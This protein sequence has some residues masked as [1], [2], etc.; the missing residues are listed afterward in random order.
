[1]I[2]NFGLIDL[3]YQGDPFTWSNRQVGENFI[4]ERLDR[5]LCNQQWLINNHTAT[6]NHLPRISS[7]NAPLLL[8]HEAIQRKSRDTF[9][10]EHMWFL[11]PKFA[12]TTQVFWHQIRHPYPA[13]NLLD[14]QQHSAVQ[15]KHWA[16]ENFGHL[17]SLIK[18][19]EIS[20][21]QAQHQCAIASV[22]SMSEWLNKEKDAR[23]THL[24]L[25]HFQE[26][27]WK[28]RSWIL[29][30]QQGDLNTTYFHTQASIHMWHNHIQQLT[31]NQGI[32]TQSSQQVCDLLVGFFSNQYRAE[33]TIIDYSLFEDIH[34][35]L[36]THHCI[37]LIAPVTFEEFELAL[38]GHDGYT[39]KFFKDLDHF[40]G[41]ALWG[42]VEH[43][44]THKH[45]QYPI[46]HTNINLIPK[47]Q[48]PK[49]PSD[50][51]PIGLCNVTY[52]VITKFLVNRLRPILQFIISPFQSA[53]V[54][55]R[56]IHGNISIAAEIFHHIISSPPTKHPKNALKLDIKKVYDRLD[57]GFVKEA[58]M[59][60]GFPN[61]F[62]QYIMACITTVTYA[63]NINGTS[64][65]HI[66]PTR[67]IRQ[68]DP[69]SPYI[70]IICAEILSTRLGKLEMDGKLEGLKISKH[71]PP[72]LHLM[73]VDDLL[74]T[75]RAK[76]ETCATHNN[77]LQIYSKLSR[78]RNK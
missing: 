65:G 18:A 15:L 64:Q 24:A 58:F 77:I 17:P 12:A 31:S 61:L 57:W 73:Y 14:K 10:L 75:C 13:Q 3:G 32:W 54:P 29:W 78:S 71:G 23:N 28:Q 60:L 43:F 76:P 46:N 16:K 40:T 20:V 47:N 30:L 69:L 33:P 8:I 50:F 19:A 1:M 72:I 55:N 68:D 66:T 5:A 49:Q 38:Q 44:F 59:K 21:M 34:T 6:I 48:N 45:I 22:E 36:S 62:I 56:A 37:A 74:I 51:R 67:G 42:M 26:V 52:K 4:L 2:N 70:F 27:Y 9:R 35:R 53:F 11:H 41:L 39:G 25:S 63:I 7:D